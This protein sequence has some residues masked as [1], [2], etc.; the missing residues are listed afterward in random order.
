M[1]EQEEKDRVKTFLDDEARNRRYESALAEIK[2]D[3]EKIESDFDDCQRLSE[4]DF[5]VRI[6]ARD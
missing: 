1:A 6:N 4:A 3:L 2:D 5:V